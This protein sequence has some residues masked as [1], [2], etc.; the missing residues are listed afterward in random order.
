MDRDYN[1]YALLRDNDNTLNPMPFVNISISPNDKYEKWI[2]GFNRLDIMSKKYYNNSFYDFF[3][4]LANPEYINEWE[5]PNNAIIRIPYPLQ[6]VK[7]E[8]ES[9]LKILVGSN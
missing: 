3:I 5:I 9:K 8:Y 6:R 1:R 7:D 2:R 4:L